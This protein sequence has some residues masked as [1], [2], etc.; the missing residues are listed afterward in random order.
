VLVYAHRLHPISLFVF[1][2]G[3]LHWPAKDGSA[4]TTE[5]RGF[6][7]VMWR[8]SSLGYALV[9]DVG[10]RELASLAAKLQSMP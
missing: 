6:N 4:L 5:D 8:Q 7:V 1:R 2:A 10:R 3:G 9:S